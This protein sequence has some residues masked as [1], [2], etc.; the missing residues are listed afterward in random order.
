[1]NEKECSRSVPIRNVHL[2]RGYNGDINLE[3]HRET[4]VFYH[5]HLGGI[6]TL[7]CFWRIEG[8]MFGG[9]KMGI[10][11][12]SSCL[13]QKDVASRR[14]YIFGL[15]TYQLIM[16]HVTL[17]VCL[18]VFI[19][20]SRCF[21]VCFSSLYLSISLPL[22]LYTC[23]SVQTTYLSICPSVY[24]SICLSIYPVYPVYPVFCL[25]CLS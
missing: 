9:E 17:S 6:M 5:R 13:N 15:Y 7:V 12:A 22:Y 24:L 16:S 20:L 8:L 1:M 11:R 10:Y 18:C 4:Q 14:W 25:S 19:C 3:T 21:Y 2:H 23:L